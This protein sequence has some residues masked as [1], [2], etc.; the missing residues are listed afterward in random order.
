MFLSQHLKLVN[1]PKL[2]QA[3]N[4]LSGDSLC[5]IFLWQLRSGNG[6][7][8]CDL[9]ISDSYVDSRGF[10]YICICVLVLLY[11]YV[12]TYLYLWPAVLRFL[13]RSEGN[14][15]TLHAASRPFQRSRQLWILNTNSW[16]LILLK[17]IWGNIMVNVVFGEI[18]EKK[19]RHVERGTHPLLETT[20]TGL[21][22]TYLKFLVFRPKLTKTKPFPPFLYHMNGKLF[23]GGS[24]FWSGKIGP[25]LAVGGHR[26]QCPAEL[27]FIFNRCPAGNPLF[28]TDKI[29]F[30][31]KYHNFY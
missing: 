30:W 29:Y 31:Q 1:I 4:F 18:V 10:V 5:V 19:W 21:R 28:L 22:R 13:R 17:R 15:L 3:K 7:L 24:R 26:S 9:W 25:K 6:L 16:I 20:L 11:L 14:V 27:S 12:C 23:L 2:V 8:T